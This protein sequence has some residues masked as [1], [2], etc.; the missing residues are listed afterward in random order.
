MGT[1]ID[2]G[3]QICLGLPDAERQIRLFIQAGHDHRQV[4][5][6][7]RFGIRHRYP[8]AVAPKTEPP[9]KSRHG[10]RE[11]ALLCCY[12]MPLY[13]ARIAAASARVTSPLGTRVVSVW[14]VMSPAA[15]SI[16]NG[17]E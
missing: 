1:C 16:V 7:P 9:P 15:G 4:G 5:P 3:N 10:I 11:A 17:I 12:F 2:P 13:R 14:P 8:S 6:E